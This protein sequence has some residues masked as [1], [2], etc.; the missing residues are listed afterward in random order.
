MPDVAAETVFYLNS[1]IPALALVAKRAVT[2]G[3][4]TR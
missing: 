4:Q 1:K 2:L 3:G